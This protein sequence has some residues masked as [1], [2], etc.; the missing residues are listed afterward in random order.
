MKSSYD[1]TRETQLLFLYSAIAIVATYYVIFGIF[2]YLYQRV[3]ASAASSNTLDKLQM[4]KHCDDKYLKA[5]LERLKM[6]P[7]RY[8][9]KK[10]KDSARLVQLIPP[11]VNAFA[12]TEKVKQCG[13]SA[14]RPAPARASVRYQLAAADVCP[15]DGSLNSSRLPTTKKTTDFAAPI[16]ESHYDGSIRAD[17]PMSTLSSTSVDKRAHLIAEQDLAYEIS[18]ESDLKKQCELQNFSES[19]NTR[20]ADADTSIVTEKEPEVKISLINSLV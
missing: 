17:G 9:L 11:E 20:D 19:S 7:E 8:E 12:E 4:T 15:L 10:L 18:V 13:Q 6:W 2:P 1:E 16:S 5:E 14:L 3:L